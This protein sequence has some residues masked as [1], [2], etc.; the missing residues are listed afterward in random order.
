M[1]RSLQNREGLSQRERLC[2]LLPALYAL[3]KREE[4]Q[5]VLQKAI[6]ERQAPVAF[7]AEL[8]IHL[9]LLI[10]FPNMLHGLEQLARLKTPLRRTPSDNL[11]SRQLQH[12]GLRALQRVYGRQTEKLLHSLAAIHVDLPR[13]IVQDVYGKVIARAGLRMQERELIN[14]T[15]LT[16]QGLDRQQYSH[17]RGALRVGV[18]PGV[19]RSVFRILRSKFRVQVDGAERSLQ[20]LTISEN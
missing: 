7:L 13:M 2:I 17:I 12:R 19:L 8:F 10:G 18:P 4:A 9:S 11:S 15:V 1:R 16:I 14:I 20:Q 6:A 3:G 5:V